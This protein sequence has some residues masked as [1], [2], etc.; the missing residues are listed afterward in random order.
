[1]TLSLIILYVLTLLY[2]AIAERF[3]NHTTILAVQGLLLFGIAIARLHE[4]HPVEMTVIIIETLVFKAIVIPAILLTVIHRTKI[5]RIHSSSTQFGALVMSI[6]ALV[7]S[8]T[9][10][11]YMADERTDMIFF[12]VALYALLSG[13]ILIVM[14][15]RIFAHLVGFLVIENGVFLFSMAIGVELPMLINLA[16]M[17]DILISILILGTFLSRVDNDIHTDESD[18][19]TSIKD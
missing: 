9:I 2:L 7:A 15:K 11:Y 12:G 18:A 17:L 3:R 6:V 16:I 5:N 19:L 8:C 1:M 14:R 4:F 10:T 13:L